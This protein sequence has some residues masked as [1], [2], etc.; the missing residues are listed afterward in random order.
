MIPKITPPTQQHYYETWVCN[1]C[2]EGKCAYCVI[3]A[4]NPRLGAFP[5]RCTKCSH[6]AQCLDCRNTNP[7]EISVDQYKCID[8]DGCRGRISARLE[9]SALWRMLQDCRAAGA[10][11]RARVARGRMKIMATLPPD[12]EDSAAPRPKRKPGAARA[13]S[14]TCL[15][16]GE[17]TRGGKF[18]PGHDAKLAAVLRTAMRDGTITTEQT[19]LVTE[20][21]WQKKVAK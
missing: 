15:C 5:C 20:L 11:E 16:C 17:P 21:G 4:R 14:G 1:P 2:K 13:K 6:P 10:A 9:R 7:D 8:P 18:L 19:A 12:E 3:A